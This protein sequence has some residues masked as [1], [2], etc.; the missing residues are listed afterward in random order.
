VNAALQSALARTCLRQSTKCA[1]FDQLW[2][3]H[4]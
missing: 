3:A 4:N 2:N 1:T